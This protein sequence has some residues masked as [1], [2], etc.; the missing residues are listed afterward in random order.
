MKRIKT[1]QYYFNKCNDNAKTNSIYL[2]LNLKKQLSRY[3]INEK[4]NLKKISIFQF[5]KTKMKQLKLYIKFIFLDIESKLSIILIQT[6]K[7]MPT[8]IIFPINE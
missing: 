6:V 3:I 7:R 2:F 5:Y 8:E 1:Y 4:Y